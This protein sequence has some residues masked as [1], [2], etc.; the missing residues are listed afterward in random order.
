[1]CS[2]LFLQ[3]LTALDALKELGVIHADLKADNI[4]LVNHQDQP[5]S[6]KLIDFGLSLQTREVRVGLTV[7]PVGCR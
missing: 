1:M 3:L 7:Q 6:V 5:F 2:S 4:M